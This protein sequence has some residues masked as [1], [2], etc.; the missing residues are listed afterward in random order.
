MKTQTYLCFEGLISDFYL[1]SLCGL[2]RP[3]GEDVAQE[4]PVDAGHG[5]RLPVH[6]QAGAQL[7]Y[8]TRDEAGSSTGT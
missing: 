4:L 2:A 8:L 3:V 6:V 1:G 7:G 5:G